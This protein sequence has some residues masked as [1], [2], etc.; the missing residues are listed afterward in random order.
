MLGSMTKPGSI[1]EHCSPPHRA[2]PMGLSFSNV[3]L[4]PCVDCSHCVTYLLHKSLPKTAKNANRVVVKTV[5]L[6]DIGG[7]M[8]V[9]ES[10]VEDFNKYKKFQH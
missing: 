9:G 6:K 4:R 10:S 8:D 1:T 7:G 2:G 5:I 3:V